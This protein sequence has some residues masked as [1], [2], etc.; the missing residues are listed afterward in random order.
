MHKH[1]EVLI[2]R[3][4]TDAEFRRRFEE[5]PVAVLLEQRM[6]LSEIE[7]AALSAL[8]PAALHAFAAVLDARLRKVSL[9]SGTG[10]T[11]GDH[12]TESSN[13]SGKENT[14]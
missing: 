4:A 2:G 10:R 14:R 1:V 5:S 9:S 12:P 13:D 6:E 3:L 7:V 8:D 11:C